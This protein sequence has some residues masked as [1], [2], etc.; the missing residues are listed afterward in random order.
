MRVQLIAECDVCGKEANVSYP[1]PDGAVGQANPRWRGPSGWLLPHG[2]T[3]ANAPLGDPDGV[4][5]TKVLCPRHSEGRGNVVDVVGS[6]E[7]RI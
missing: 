4:R 5:Q 2:E 1:I 6:E 7:G 3:N